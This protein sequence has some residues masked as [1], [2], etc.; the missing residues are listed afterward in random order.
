MLFRSGQTIRSFEG[1]TREQWT[2]WRQRTANICTVTHMADEDV[3]TA[4]TSLAIGCFKTGLRLPGDS[5][6]HQ[7]LDNCEALW[8]KGVDGGEP[9]HA[10]GSREVRWMTSLTI[11]KQVHYAALRAAEN[12]SLDQFEGRTH[13]GPLEQE[14]A[15]YKIGRAHV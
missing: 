3:R 9:F 12:L 2:A 10:A 8:R 4:I 14:L 1:T 7:T 6:L 15:N 5:S 13:Y 11:T